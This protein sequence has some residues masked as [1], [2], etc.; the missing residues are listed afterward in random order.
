MALSEQSF[1][2]LGASKASRTCHICGKVLATANSLHRHLAHV[3]KAG[4]VV[5]EVFA[6]P[7][8]DMWKC[9]VCKESCLDQQTLTMHQQ[10]HHSGI[11]FTYEFRCSQCPAEFDTA[12]EAAN[13]YQFHSKR[14][15]PSQP[16]PTATPNYTRPPSPMSSRFLY[17]ITPHRCQ[18]LYSLLIR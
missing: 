17:T 3:H 11:L 2:Q 13:H 7:L 15:L 18:H 12:R 14:L 4:A 10:H 8:P 1:S 9:S 5:S 16:D 6:Y